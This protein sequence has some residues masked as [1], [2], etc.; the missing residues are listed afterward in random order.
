MAK[1]YIDTQYH[2]LLIRETWIIMGQ[3]FQIH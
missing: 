2:L 3:H 1:K